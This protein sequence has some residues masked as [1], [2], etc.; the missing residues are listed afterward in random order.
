FISFSLSKDE[1]SFRLDGSQFWVLSIRGRAAYLLHSNSRKHCT[2][3]KIA[4]AAT[5]NP[6]ARCK[7]RSCWSTRPSI[8]AMR[9]E[10]PS[11]S[12]VFIWLFSTERSASTRASNSVMHLSFAPRAS[13]PSWAKRA[14]PAVTEQHLRSP[15]SRIASNSAVLIRHTYERST[16]PLQILA[17]W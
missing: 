2:N 4:L 5:A 12:R 6:L 8:A 17:E 13:A 7:L 11:P 16:A 3:V 1:F 10:L 15:R 9:P 14:Y